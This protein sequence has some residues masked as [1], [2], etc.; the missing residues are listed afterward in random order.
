MRQ[1]I[2]TKQSGQI[3]GSILCLLGF[4]ALLLVFWKAWPSASG[5]AD[6]FSALWSQVLNG[7]I[8]LGSLLVL[9][10]V[11]LMIG[12]SALLILGIAVLALSRQIFYVS[13]ESTL[14][15]CPY[16]R[17]QWKARRAMG[18]AEC[19]F[20]RKFIHPQTVKKI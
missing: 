4:V 12:G 18:W 10:L 14:I 3:L 20:C 19:P 2:R 9:K 17:N 7:Q 11:Y 6:V 15:Q 8:N 16:C 5:S 1:I 13:G